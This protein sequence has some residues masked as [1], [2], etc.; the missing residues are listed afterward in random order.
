MAQKQ[1]FYKKK[2]KIKLDDFRNNCKKKEFWELSEELLNK[3]W[4]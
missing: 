4:S 3:I 1:Q 2:F